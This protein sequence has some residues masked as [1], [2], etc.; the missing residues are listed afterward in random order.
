MANISFLSGSIYSTAFFGI[1][2]YIFF[3]VIRY[4]IKFQ[5][6]RHFFDA[7]PGYSS[8]QK[9]WIRGNLHLY[10]KN[11]SIDVNQIS[12]LT[13]RFPKFY[14][15]WFGPFTPVVSLVHPDSVK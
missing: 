10:V 7:L 4:L 5:R 2:V 9:H 14:R 8:K 13:R 3:V 1:T 12:S 11:D 15:V 6:M